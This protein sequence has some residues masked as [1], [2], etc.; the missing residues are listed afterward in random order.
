[1]TALVVLIVGV[2]LRPPTSDL[3][4]LVMFLIATGGGT[5]LLGLVFPYMPLPRKLT[6]FRARLVLISAITATLAL[7]N[8]GVTA[9]L[10]F[11]SFHDLILLLGLLVFSVGIAVFVALILAEPTIQS[12]RE[13]LAAAKRMSGGDLDIRVK[14]RSRDEVGEIGQAFNE[15]AHRLEEGQ[16]RQ[17]EL[18]RARRDLVTAVSHD[19]RTPLASVRAMVESMSD[20]VVADPDTVK[21]YL[22]TT[23]SEVDSLSQLVDD[24]FELSQIDAGMLQL[25]I[26]AASIDDLISDTLESMRA[27]AAARELNLGGNVE[28]QPLSVLMDTRRV[29]RVLYNLVQNSI[30]HTPRDGT[31]FVRARDAGKDIE[32]E[33]A[34]TG[35]GISDK[36]IPHVFNRSYRADQSRSRGS[37]G[38]GLGLSIAKGIVEAHGG[39]IWVESN[40]GRGSKFAF[41]LPKGKPGYASTA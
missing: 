18:E 17:Q 2:W 31:I 16:S 24:L 23:L 19:L 5:V 32:V 3:S 12:V 25:H 30:R 15:M 27:Q 37:G 14:A 20:G 10:M 33:V 7:A 4:A 34:D 6:G 40:E 26:E 13:L 1:M 41:T 22:R 8:V 38:A 28:G 39:Q 35:E 9:S 21:R 11:L 36:D 29:Q